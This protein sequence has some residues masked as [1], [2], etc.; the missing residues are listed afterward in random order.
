MPWSGKHLVYRDGRWFES[1]LADKDKVLVLRALK[2]W[3]FM[4]QLPELS[5]SRAEKKTFKFIATELTH[6]PWFMSPG[7]CEV[8]AAPDRGLSP[9]GRPLAHLAT[10]ACALKAL[11][12]WFEW[13]KKEGVWDKTTVVIASDH[14]SGDDPAFSRV[15]SEAGMQN[16]PARANSLLMVRRAGQ[17]GPLRTETTPMTGAAAVSAW[18]GVKPEGPR[19][20]VIAKP[21]GESYVV[22]KVWRLDGS[23]FNAKNWADQTP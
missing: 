13:M 2:D 16:A 10:E 22:D 19:T 21:H 8:T 11:A 1:F 4:D 20:H 9:E 3:A 5:N 17:T 7:K 23:M 12:S 14:S 6:A 18:T 15:F